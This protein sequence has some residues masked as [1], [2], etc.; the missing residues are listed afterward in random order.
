MAGKK[1]V[2]DMKINWEEAAAMAQRFSPPEEI[3]ASLGIT[4]NQFKRAVRHTF[5]KSVAAW[6]DQHAAV[7]RYLVRQRQFERAVTDGNTQLLKWLGIQHLGQREHVDVIHKV[8]PNAKGEG[9]NE[10]AEREKGFAILT[11]EGMATV[12]PAIPGQK[13]LG[14]PHDETPIVEAVI[15]EE[16]AKEAKKTAPGAQPETEIESYGGE[17]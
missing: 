6:W 14:Q 17:T 5:K 11:P 10:R 4:P 7:G 8:D 16:L 15:V 3:Q 9:A 12:L 2:A 13:Q 1:P